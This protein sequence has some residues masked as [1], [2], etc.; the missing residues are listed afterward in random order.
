MALAALCALAVGILWSLQ[1]A[2]GA[3]A[4]DEVSRADPWGERGTF[5]YAPLL[6]DGSGELPMGEPG[7]FTTDA[8][9]VRVSFAWTLDDASAERVAAM[10]DLFLVARH[11]SPAWTERIPIAQG[12]YDGAADGPLLLSG[13]IDLPAAQARIMETPGR[14]ASDATWAFVANVRFASAPVAAHKA[15]AS[16]FELPLTYTPPLYTLPGADGASSAKD[17]A[18]EIVAHHAAPS[19]LA[20]LVAR[21]AGPALV[22]L[23]LVGLLLYLRERPAEEDAA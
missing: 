2:T 15:D 19:P 10:G 14:D 5:T 11:E 8:P 12:T 7:Y 4:Y 18:R 13:E 16:A 17:H 3:H 9:R 23:G 20:S 6:A 21:P 22:A 1:A